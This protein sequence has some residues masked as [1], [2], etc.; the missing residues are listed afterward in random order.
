VKIEKVFQEHG[1][2]NKLGI[3]LFGKHVFGIIYSC[4]ESTAFQ[5]IG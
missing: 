2:G 3:Q 1:A 4:D 5:V